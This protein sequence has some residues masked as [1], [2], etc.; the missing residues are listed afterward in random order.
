MKI[1]HLATARTMVLAVTSALCLQAASPSARAGEAAA[2]SEYPY[3]I[4]FE[5]GATEFAPGDNIVITSIRGNRRH[6]ES[7]GRYLVEGSYALAAADGADLALHATSRGPSGPS[8]VMRDQQVEIT[9]GTGDFH[10]TKTLRD[11][12]WLHISF[13]VN[14][15]SH[16]GIYFGEQGVE[17][18]ILREKGWSDF[19]SD[20]AS[21]RPGREFA[22]GESVSALTNEANLAILAYL[23]NPVP[24]PAG[25]DAK[26]NR[27]NLRAAFTVLS[28]KADLRVK[29]LEVDESEFPFLA[30][31]VLTGKC[32]F[33]VLEKG[34]REMNGYSYGGSVVGHTNQRATYFALNMIPHDQYPSDRCDRRLMIRLQMLADKA[35]RTE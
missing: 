8:P 11:D 30:Y 20:S 27:T 23:G 26:Y 19:S 24:A 25:L 21:A 10:L 31:G 12:G 9:R 15:H 13:Y 28:K 29:A 35:R 34:L 14:G 1:S 6:L 22:V 33:Q 18:T 16:G 5:L 2:E 7:G 4:Q 32:D 17:K 3:L